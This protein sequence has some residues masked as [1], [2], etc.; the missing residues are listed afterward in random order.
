MKATGKLTADYPEHNVENSIDETVCENNVNNTQEISYKMVALKL[1]KMKGTNKYTKCFMSQLR[2]LN[3]VENVLLQVVYE[4]ST[5]LTEAEK[6][7]KSEQIQNVSTKQAEKVS[8]RCVYEMEFGE[9]FDSMIKTDESSSE[10]EEDDPISLYCMKK[11]AVDSKLVD[12]AVYNVILNP[13]NI[14]ISATNC[15]EINKDTYKKIED[16]ILKFIKDDDFGF[17]EKQ[18]Q[19]AMEKYRQGN[20]TEKVSRILALKEVGITDEQYK[21]ERQIFAS[22]MADT[23]GSL[24]ECNE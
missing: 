1:R 11:Y 22:F 15:D 16:L 13:K 7:F 3:W 2:A 20:F 4:A 18:V 24:V 10:E 19:C 5:T 6:K 21:S 12:T 17:T 8:T 14:D 9:F 23:T